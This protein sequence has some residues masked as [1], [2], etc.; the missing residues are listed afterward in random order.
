METWSSGLPEQVSGQRSDATVEVERLR[1]QV[2]SSEA[3]RV[4]DCEGQ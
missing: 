3:N 4:E 2:S 1:E